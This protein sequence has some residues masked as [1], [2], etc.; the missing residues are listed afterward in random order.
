MERQRICLTT[1]ILIE[2]PANAMSVK[3]VFLMDRIVWSMTLSDT[4]TLETL[5]PSSYAALPSGSVPY[6]YSIRKA[7]QID[8]ART[9]ASWLLHSRAVSLMGSPTLQAC[10]TPLTSVHPHQHPL[11]RQKTELSHCSLMLSDARLASG[12]KCIAFGVMCNIRKTHPL[13]DGNEFY[14]IYKRHTDGNDSCAS[15]SKRRIFLEG[16]V[17]PTE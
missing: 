1:V 10:S 4:S 8:L 2:Y 12:R 15:W 3:A 9:L 17:V 16:Y 5:V 6:R 7:L 11:L 14:V 13:V